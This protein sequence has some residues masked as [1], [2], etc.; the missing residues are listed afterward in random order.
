MMDRR[1]SL[2]VLAA[3]AVLATACSDIAEPVRP[4]APGG[5]DAKGGGG[6]GGGGG[7][8]TAPNPLPTAAPAPGILMRESFGPGPDHVRPAGGQGT[9][10][11][12]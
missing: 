4:L 5:I 1:I 9:H 2:A 10:K 8:V 6:A 12:T 3:T 7:T 11:A